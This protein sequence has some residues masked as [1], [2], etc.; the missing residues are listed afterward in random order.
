MKRRNRGRKE[1]RQRT[2]KVEDEKGKD[3]KGM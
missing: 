1:E 3:G 2:G